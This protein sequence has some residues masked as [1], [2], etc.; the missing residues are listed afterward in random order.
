MARAKKYRRPRPV[1]SNYV[2][3]ENAVAEAIVARLRRSRVL[4][5]PQSLQQPP[6][7]AGK[8]DA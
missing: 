2:V 1:V 5:A 8:P 7:G 4:V 3:D 6:A